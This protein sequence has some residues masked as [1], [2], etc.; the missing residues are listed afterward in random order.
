LTL[1]LATYAEA[2][3]WFTP[4]FSSGAFTKLIATAVTFGVTTLLLRSALV[5]M[6]AA[7][8]RARR[9]AE[10]LES[11]NVELVAS[12]DELAAQTRELERRSRYLEATAAVARDTTLELDLRSLLPRLASLV[13]E[14]L[15]FYHTGIFFLEPGGQ[16]LELEAASSEGGQR[17]LARGHRLRIGEGIVGYAAQQ[18]RYRLALDV[19]ADA[20][21]FDNPDLPQTRSEVALP[22]VARGDVIGVL[23]VQSTEPQAFTDED[24]A[25]LQALANQLAVA[26]SNAR[27]FWEAQRALESERGAYGELSRRAWQELLQAQPELAIVRDEQGILPTDSRPDA[28]VERALQTGQVALGE[29]GKDERQAVG[30]AVPIRVRGQ[31]IGAID[32]HK[33]AEGGQWTREQIALLATLSEQV[34]DALEDA[35]LYQEAQRRAAHEQLTGEVAARIRATLDVDTVLQTAVRE[36]REALDFAEVEVRLGR[37][38]SFG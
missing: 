17:M 9:N 25:A 34:G 24:M 15:G 21:F 22:L 38:S 6:F 3:G 33:P 20:V 35:R 19:G 1:A 27:L 10:A 5:S 32:A 13:S 12:R 29:D 31:V 7:F 4:V 18:R 36:M 11:S 28:E 14:Q 26:I 2:N 16:W 23:D 30:L 8:R 37:P